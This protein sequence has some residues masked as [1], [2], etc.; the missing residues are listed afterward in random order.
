RVEWPRPRVLDFL[1][2]RPA[3]IEY[4]ISGIED[5]RK[6]KPL[7]DLKPTEKIFHRCPSIQRRPLFFPSGLLQKTESAYRP[8]GKRGTDANSLE[9]WYREKLP[10]WLARPRY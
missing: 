8:A 2:Q 5:I 3:Q 1:C 4:S 6:R 10:G 9:L 7:S